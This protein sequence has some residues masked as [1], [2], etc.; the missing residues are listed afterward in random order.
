VIQTG[1]LDEEQGI[2]ELIGPV[3]PGDSLLSGVV[4]GLRDGA[5]VRVIKES[6]GTSTR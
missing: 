2:I 1:L 4:P 5:R 6:G 3:Q